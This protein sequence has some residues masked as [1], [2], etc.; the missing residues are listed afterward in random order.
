MFSFSGSELKRRRLEAGLTQ[1]Q[2]ARLV[3]RS[4]A[5]VAHYEIGFSLPP[6]AALLRLA[7]A[8]QCEPGA[9]F[10]PEPDRTEAV[11]T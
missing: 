8:L 2:L 6:I 1:A 11:M 5:S 4:N 9:L 7:S 10:R 3:G